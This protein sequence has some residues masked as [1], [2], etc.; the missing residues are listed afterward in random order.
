MISK[1]LIGLVPESKRYILLSVIMQILSLFANAVFMYVVT[2]S[3]A[4]AFSSRGIGNNISV[5]IMAA[6]LTI[7]IR[8]LCNIVINRVSFLSSRAVKTALRS[9]LYK[10][11][12][13]L[14]YKYN[15]RFTL[16]EL[17][18][19]STEGIEQLEIYFAAYLPQF[20]YSMTAPVIL[21]A[22]LFPIHRLTAIVLL[23]CVPMIPVAI[24]LVQ[25]VAKK[26]LS[27]YWN[28]YTS[29]GSSFLDNLQGLTTLKIYNSDEYKNQE[30]NKEAEEFRKITMRVLSMQLN[31]IIIM[32][33]IAYGGAALG[34]FTALMG[35]KSGSISMAQCFFII[36][37]SADFF[38]P[39]RQM[40]SLFHVAMNGM[41]ASKKLFQIFESDTEDE[42][43]KR[44]L[45]ND[46][47]IVLENLCFSYDGKKEV[48][49]DLNLR[50]NVGSYAI[51]GNS[52]SGK[53]T[54]ASILSGKNKNYTGS[55]KIGGTELSNVKSDCLHKALVYIGY[56][57]F[58]FKGTVRENLKI[59]D[60]NADDGKMWE[61]LKRVN[62]N[63]FFESE[64]GLD[65]MLNE[66]ASNL[67]G[68]Q[69]QRLALA[70]A[71]LFDSDIYIF[72]EATSNI[73]VE[74]ENSIM[75]EARELSKSKTVI[76]ISHRLANVVESD[77][78]YVLDNSRL[79]EVG[80]HNELLKN[81]GH[82]ADLWETQQSLERYVG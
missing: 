67:S 56:D 63:G 35:L 80:T 39:M 15:E 14:S 81:N 5:L 44:D 77:K 48:L 34:I 79:A 69:R 72:D 3:I 78:I 11:L 20:F 41:A 71:L 61:V 75:R 57:S 76:I 31:S 9:K 18:Q 64:N 62:L 42:D 40:G 49:S 74:S 73:D 4:D 36:L 30:M 12:I 28:K 38:I 70:R 66:R 50:F 1:R 29:L 47:E 55:C 46:R 26:L 59:A 65:T 6:I 32:D 58:L 17:T 37:I 53:S 13:Q 7:G 24:A 43:K 25:T 54:L 82:Y 10:K 60:E 52:G 45:A 16:S 21:F 22:I 27:K 19:L 23:V 8:F 33:L 68:G 51:V 2:D